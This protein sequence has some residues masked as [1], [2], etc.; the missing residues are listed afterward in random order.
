MTPQQFLST[1]MLPAI[2][3]FPQYDSPEA[4]CLLL[5]IAGQESNWAERVQQP[6]GYARGF[7]QCEEGGAVADVL[8]SPDTREIKDLCTTLCIPTSI[9]KVWEAIAWNDCL[10]YAIAR[11]N[12]WLDPH[13]LPAIGDSPASWQTYLR[14]WK[15]GRPSLVRWASVYPAAAACFAGVP[16]A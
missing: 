7:W 13:P 11:L 16:I 6:V 8:T 3:L 14:A 12:L 4:R 15:P 9:A 5:A 1:I 2:S 10:A